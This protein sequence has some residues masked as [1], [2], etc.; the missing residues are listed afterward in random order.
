MPRPD[1][2]RG[3]LFAVALCAGPVALAQDAALLKDLTAA[4]RL[5]GLPCGEVIS[6]RRQAESDHIATCASGERYRVF[7]SRQGRLTAQKQP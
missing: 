7:V 4:I 2:R 3:A 5:L 6:A 1:W